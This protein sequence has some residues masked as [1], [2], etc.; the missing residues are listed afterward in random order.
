VHPAVDRAAVNAIRRWRYE[1][2]RVTEQ[3]RSIV[4]RFMMIFR[5]Q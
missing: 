4:A 2:A 5:L 3:P 1:P